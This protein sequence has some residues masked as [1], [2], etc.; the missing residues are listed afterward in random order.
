[1]FAAF[2]GFLFHFKFIL[3]LSGFGF[4]L[5]Q[6]KINNYMIVNNLVKI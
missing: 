4:Y 2:V 1:M 6:M 5:N 3:C